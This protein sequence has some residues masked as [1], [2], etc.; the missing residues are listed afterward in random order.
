MLPPPFGLRRHVL[1]CV[2][3]GHFSL[4]DVNCGIYIE[5][6]MQEK[7]RLQKIISDGQTGVDRAALD[8]GFELGIPVGGYC[9]KGRR[10]EDGAIPDEMPYEYKSWLPANMAR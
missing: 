8:V 10:S 3:G 7:V 6:W 5:G 4:A 2:I 9:P 1:V